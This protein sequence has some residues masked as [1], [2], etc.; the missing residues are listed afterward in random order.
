M[1]RSERLTQDIDWVTV[2]LYLICLLA[3]WANIYAAVYNPETHV[4]ILDFSINS[5]KQLMWIGSSVLLI[6]AIMVIDYKFYDFFAYIIYG[7][8]LASLV[9]VMLF[10]RN[11]NGQNAWFEIGSLRIQPSEFA[12]FATA[13]ALAKYLG[14]RGVKFSEPRTRLIALGIIALPA[15]LILLQNDTGSALVFG[16][17]VLVLYREGLSPWIL[18]AGVA[19][20]AVLML[21]LVFPPLYLVGGLVLA[22]GALILSFRRKTW[23]RIRWVV[24]GVALVSVMIFGVQYAFEKV[25]QPHQQAR[26]RVL[27]DPEKY[28]R[29]EG[30][31][32]IQSKI[33]IGS[34][35]WLG[36][37][38]L[39]GTQTK[40]DFVPEQST[41]FIFCTIGEEHGW[42][43]GM[44][45]IALMIGL[46]WRLTFLAERQKDRF[47]RI[48]GYSVASIL[49]FHFAVNIGMTIG[50]MPV[51]GIPLPFFSYGGS[52]LW[53]FTVLLFIF[54]KLDSHRMQILTH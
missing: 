48:Y 17:F 54:L 19:G 20:V 13:L 14:Q 6:V 44:V 33:A 5:G 41:D 27:I 21:S 7:L 16:S 12:K 28:A 40:F 9:G 29:K 10:A 26:I 51:I 4:S 35:G 45:V 22:G 50:L 37:G 3:G 47:A 24:V 53:S 25:L 32:V 23:G 38:F 39:Q 46:L 1:V 42:L 30:Y 49:F 43:G 18:I 34:G 52:S 36:K 15:L 31:N 8:L 2:L 11:I